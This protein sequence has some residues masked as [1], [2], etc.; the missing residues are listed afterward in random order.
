MR[1]WRPSTDPINRDNNNFDL[2]PARSPTEILGYWI[3]RYR[4]LNILNYDSQMTWDIQRP[5]L[6]ANDVPGGASEWLVH[7]ALRFAE[8]RIPDL[9]IECGWDVR[10]KDQSR[11]DRDKF[12]KMRDDFVRQEIRPL[13]DQLRRW[14]EID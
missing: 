8:L 2:I 4:R 3:D 5:T 9:Y 13:K 7:Q 12:I 1:D 10:S 6:S 11:F 14:Q